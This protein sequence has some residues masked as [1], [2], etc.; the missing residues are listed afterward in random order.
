M[1]TVL[2]EKTIDELM[3]AYANS[4]KMELGNNLKAVILYGSCARGEHEI[5]S[6]MDVFVLVDNDDKVVVDIIDKLAIQADWDY[7]TLMVCT[8]RT[9]DVYTKYYHETLY[10]EI[11][12]EGKVYYGAA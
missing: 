6:D 2:E 8:I 9:V 3:N 11:R 7:D 5:G 1:T 10:Q 12:K 4:L